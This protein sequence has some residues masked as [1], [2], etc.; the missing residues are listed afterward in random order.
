MSQMRGERHVVEAE[1]LGHDRQR[2]AG[3]LADAER[4]VACLATHGDDDV[5]AARG[6]G[7]LHQV[8]YELDADVPRG[9]ETEGGHVRRQRQI[10]VDRLRHVHAADGAVRAAR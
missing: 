7:V 6:P 5:P 4:E 2:G 1:F 3:R 9:L 8:A 10:V